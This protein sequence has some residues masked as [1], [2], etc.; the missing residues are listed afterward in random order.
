MIVDKNLKLAAVRTAV[1]HGRRPPVGTEPLLLLKGSFWATSLPLSPALR[2][3]SEYFELVVPH[4]RRCV[5]HR[6]GY[7]DVRSVELVEGRFFTDVVFQLA[8][9]TELVAPGIR[10]RDLAPAKAHLA[11]VIP[12]LLASRRA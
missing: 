7:K 4:L 10:N 9:R 8:G 6:V 5:V 2:L 1:V 11:R 12:C 3:R